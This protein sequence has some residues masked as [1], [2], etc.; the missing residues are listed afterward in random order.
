MIPSS[1]Q[2]AIYDAWSSTNSN[3]L[4]QAVAG[5]GK[6]TVILELIKRS[7]GTVLYVAFN[8]SI[9]E[10]VENKFVEKGIPSVKATAMTL[11]ALG[12]S[13]VKNA[14]YRVKIEG[15]KNFKL[16]KTIEDQIKKQ[17]KGLPYEERTRL[18]Y[19]L[20]DYLDTSRIFL[21]DDFDE[22]TKKLLMMDKIPY[23]HK[24]LKQFWE[25]FKEAREAEYAKDVNRETVMIDFLDMIYLPAR[26]GL[27]VPV[28]PDYLFIDEAQDLNLCQHKIID[29]LINQG[30]IK[31]WVAVGDSN[32]CQPKGTKVLMSDFTEKNIEDLK[33]GDTV[34]SYNIKKCQFVGFG[35]AYNV[36]PMRILNTRISNRVDNIFTVTLDSG[37]ISSYTSNHKCFLQ[38]NEEKMKG[39]YV[40]Y[41]MKKGKSFRVGISPCSSKFKSNCFA[42]IMRARAEQADCFWVLKIVNSRKEAYLHEQIIS[43]KFRIP[44]IRFKDNTTI[45][46]VMTQEDLN[47]FWH[48]MKDLTENAKNVLRYFSRE[49]DFPIWSKSLNNQGGIGNSWK[50]SSKAMFKT[51][52]CNILP[53]IMDMCVFDINNK[54]KKGRTV[55]QL[56]GIKSLSVEIKEEEFI[57]LDVERNHNYIAD[58][59]L[60]S[61]SIYGFSG[62]Y[63]ESFQLFK[64]KP[65]VVE[66]PLDICYRCPQKVITSANYVYNVMEG[67]KQDEGEVTEFMNISM[68]EEISNL[69]SNF[70]KPDTIVLCRNK[71]PLIKLL[72]SLLKEGVP[73]RLFGDDIL[74]TIMNFIKPYRSMSIE[75]AQEKIKREL[76]AL[77]LKENKTEQEKIK[78]FVLRENY[79]NFMLFA[80][81]LSTSPYEIVEN[82]VA[83]IQDL[84]DSKGND[85]HIVKLCTI[86]KSK[87]LEASHV[88]IMNENLIPSKFAKSPSQLLQEKNLIYVA[89]TRAKQSMC[90][91]NFNDL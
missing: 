28:A 44:Q 26:L 12:L 5:S 81:N 27:H 32:Q 10:E 33:I 15:S 55:K 76:S 4:V 46:S 40:I 35:T 70:S 47:I 18:M 57:S 2:L 68:K 3:L 9:K 17:T 60:T 38:L 66:L 45:N 65:N 86:H 41:L 16:Y 59:I 51:Q 34:I 39:K 79:A 78:F 42:P 72:F 1:K 49:F 52:S 74:S 90:F 20:F 56:S 21:T 77:M 54:D 83:K 58:G 88:I 62:A 91:V 37:Q 67:F 75:T 63:P 14:L 80:N 71:N 48:E 87:G 50:I 24:K 85:E 73:A 23:E 25:L 13:A 8:K 19:T 69:K 30:T 36:Q 31:K 64:T 61:N 82:L 7:Q 29:N 22:I 84:F 6:T 43:Y 11:H 89:R 53:E